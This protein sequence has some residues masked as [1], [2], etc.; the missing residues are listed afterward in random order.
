MLHHYT[1]WVEVLFFTESPS[2]PLCSSHGPELSPPHV[3]SP[4]TSFFFSIQLFGPDFLYSMPQLLTC[5]PTPDFSYPNPPYPLLALLIPL[6]SVSAVCM[7]VCEQ[8][9][10]YCTVRLCRR[11]AGCSASPLS[12]CRHTQRDTLTPVFLCPMA[13]QQHTLAHCANVCVCEWLQLLL[14]IQA[15]SSF[16]ASFPP[17]MKIQRQHSYW[18]RAGQEGAEKEG[19]SDRRKRRTTWQYSVVC[20][21]LTQ[22]MNQKSNW[23]LKWE[24]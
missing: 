16:S 7:Y 12:L 10:S 13:G 20:A 5:I 15:A 8:D 9:W 2:L 6:C 23:K 19:S 14:A 17:L 21:P 3:L 11:Y 18:H 22:K 4:T 24:N 1:A